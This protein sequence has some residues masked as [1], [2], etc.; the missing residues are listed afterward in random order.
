MN[1]LCMNE[2]CDHYKSQQ[3]KSCTHFAVMSIISN[4]NREGNVHV[5]CGMSV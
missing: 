5:Y 4:V 1:D 3:I 2:V